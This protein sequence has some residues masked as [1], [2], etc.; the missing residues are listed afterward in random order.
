MI[1]YG[2]YLLWQAT[3]IQAQGML[4]DGINDLPG[5]KVAYIIALETAS[6]S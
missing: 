3:A 4:T 2:Q 5:L 6:S 1:T